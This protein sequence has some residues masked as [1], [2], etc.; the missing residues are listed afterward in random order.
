MGPR[1][2][3]GGTASPPPRRTRGL[4]SSH[5]L[6]L[7]PQPAFSRHSSTH[8]ETPDA[9][10]SWPADRQQRFQTNSTLLTPKA[11]SFPVLPRFLP[12]ADTALGLLATLKQES[13][14]CLSPLLPCNCSLPPC[15]CRAV[16][17]VPHHPAQRSVNI[18]LLLRFLSSNDT[19]VSPRQALGQCVF[20]L[21]L[22]CVCVPGD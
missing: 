6:E 3:S 4:T 11:L 1:N 19:P 14:S 5:R 9:P 2:R 17:I 16:S 13:S 22:L 7:R 20:L 12:Q 18:S 10:S 8:T 15:G 21:L